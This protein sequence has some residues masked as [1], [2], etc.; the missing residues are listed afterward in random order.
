MNRTTAI[1][2]TI[3]SVVLCGCPGLF[4][5][6][7]GGL[8]AAGAPINTELNGVTDSTTL[9]TSYGIG[10]LCLALIFI[11]I[12]VAVGFFTLRSKPAAPVTSTPVP[13]PPPAPPIPPA[14]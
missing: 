12:P 2:L 1:I 6:V 11:L 10:M 7:F 9:P 5:C 3:A 14:S 8:V 4:L 13:P